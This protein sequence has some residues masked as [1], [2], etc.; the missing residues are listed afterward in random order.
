MSLVTKVATMITSWQAF[1]TGIATRIEEDMLKYF[2]ALPTYTEQNVPCGQWHTRKTTSSNTLTIY[3]TDNNESTGTGVFDDLNLCSIIPVVQR[4]TTADNEAPWAY[5][6]SISGNTVVLGIKR[7]NTGIIVLGGAYQG[8]T[9]NNNAVT[10][11]LT[12]TGPLNV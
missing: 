3:V 6:Q 1:V 5:I 12:I 9:N 4:N 11:H 2:T 7:S 8:N 10:V